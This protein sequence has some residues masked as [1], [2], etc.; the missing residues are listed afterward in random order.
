M[1]GA[2]AA[3]L[4]PML[5]KGGTDVAGSMIS[6]RAQGHAADKQAE[7][8]EKGI[9]LQEKMYNQDRADFAPYRAL[10]GGAVGNL[11]YLSGINLPAESSPQQSQ[12]PQQA[13]LTLADIG[14]NGQ[15]NM[16]WNTALQ[17]SVSGVNQAFEAMNSG[18]LGPTTKVT[19]NGQTRVIPASLLPK[20]LSDGYT[21]VQ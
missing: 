21:Q 18:K 1:T 6:S 8:I 17:K 20:A 5:V 14:S 12:Q 11:A 16:P 9:A 15:G 10:G 19:K 4:V 2:T 13:P 3:W 7:A